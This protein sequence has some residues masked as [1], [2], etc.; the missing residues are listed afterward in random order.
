MVGSGIGEDKG[1][2]NPP[3]RFGPG[4]R[5]QG[6]MVKLMSSV[7]MIG[8][9]LYGVWCAVGVVIG[10]GVDRAVAAVEDLIAEMRK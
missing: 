4:P 2:A 10:L 9:F 5:D 8:A 3:E 6:L 7:F 1:N